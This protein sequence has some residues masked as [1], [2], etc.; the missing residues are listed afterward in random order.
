MSIVMWVFAI[1]S[2]ID[3]LIY[4]YILSEK[5]SDWPW[6]KYLPGGAIIAFFIY[7]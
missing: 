3:L 2:T 4:L 7:K 1:F 5:R 6:W